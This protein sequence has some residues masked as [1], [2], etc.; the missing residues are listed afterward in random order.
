MG[1]CS[2]WWL[3][4]FSPCWFSGFLGESVC[5]VNEYPAAMGGQ[6]Q[7][8]VSWWSPWQI[9]AI[10]QLEPVV[11]EF[12]C[13]SL[14]AQGCDLAGSCERVGVEDDLQGAGLGMIPAENDRFTAGA[15]VELWGWVGH[16][17]VPTCT[18]VPIYRYV[19]TTFWGWYVPWYGIIDPPE[20][21]LARP[22]ICLIFAMSYQ[23]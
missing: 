4:I 7:P 5:E 9:P 12:V 13:G 10:S 17:Y 11:E 23:K 22:I 19:R 21:R 8:M 15:F 3:Q 6:N 20:L 18:Y 1:D 16:Q 2:K 14:I